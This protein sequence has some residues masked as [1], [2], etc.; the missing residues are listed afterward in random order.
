MIKKHILSE[1]VFRTIVAALK[2]TTQLTV[3]QSMPN[4][5]LAQHIT[6]VDTLASIINTLLK[7]NPRYIVH[8]VSENIPSSLFGSLN[9]FLRIYADGKPVKE[10]LINFRIMHIAPKNTPFNIFILLGTIL[11]FVR[12]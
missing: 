10:D 3:L 8:L 1:D 9:S 6:S 5:Q 11:D 7:H 2:S 12:R 4:K